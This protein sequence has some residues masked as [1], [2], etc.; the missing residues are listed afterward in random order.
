MTKPILLLFFVLS[1]L[2]SS[3]YSSDA[4]RAI[5]LNTQFHYSDLPLFTNKQFTHLK[6]QGDATTIGFE[7]VYELSI[8]S[9]AFL[10]TGIGFEQQKSHYIGDAVQPE[11]SGF[12]TTKW[13]SIQVP[14]LIKSKASWKELTFFLQTGMSIGYGVDVKME[15]TKDLFNVKTPNSEVVNFSN[16]GLSRFDM[17]LRLGVGVERYLTTHL[18]TAL[19]LFYNAGAVNLYSNPHGVFRNKTMTLAIGVFRDI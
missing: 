8:A 1:L 5:G 14:F 3:P 19:S 11:N 9:W 6:K 13:S 17:R 2:I 16:L 18:K 4:Q 15:F 12:Y 10:Q 7:L